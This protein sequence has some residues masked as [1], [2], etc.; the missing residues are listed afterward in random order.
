MIVEDVFQDFRYEYQR[1][2]KAHAIKEAKIQIKNGLICDSTQ[3]QIRF[4]SSLVNLQ[5]SIDYN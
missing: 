2:D 5:C 1:I 3:I 4:K